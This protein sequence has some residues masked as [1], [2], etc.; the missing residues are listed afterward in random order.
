MESEYW[1]T[2][3]LEWKRKGK[4]GFTIPFIIGSQQFLPLKHKQQD[5]KGL[6]KD[7]ANNTDTLVVIKY[8]IN[9]EDI[10]L[11]IKENIE[12]FPG[13]FP[14]IQN[15]QQDKLFLTSPHILNDLGKS[16]ESIITRFIERY[17]IHIDKG[18]FSKYDRERNDYLPEEKEFIKRAFSIYH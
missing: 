6:I 11:E 18:R 5:I 17:Q 15:N 7:I 1:K 13:F 8:C 4:S 3:L 12:Y 2:L 14:T 9:T 10:I 16:C